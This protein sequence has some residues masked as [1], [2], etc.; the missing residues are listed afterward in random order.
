MEGGRRFRRCLVGGTFDRLHAGHRLL[1]DAAQTA[2][3]FVEI[4]ITSDA[5]A[6]QKSDHIQSFETRRECLLDWIEQHA[7]RR[8][9]VHQLT[10][11]HGPAPTHSKADCIVATPETRGQ[12][13]RINEKRLAGNLPPLAV[14]EVG[15]MMDINGEVISSSRIRNGHI[16]PEGH[17]WF[18][19]D[20]E[21]RTLRMHPRAEPELKSPM[22]VL[23]AGPEDDPEI[24]MLAALDDLDLDRLMLVAVGDVTVRT[25]LSIGITPDL[26]LV[27]GQTKR[28]ALVKEEQVNIGAFGTVLHAENPA[29][30]LTPSLLGAVRE[31]LSD[32]VPVVVVVDGEEDLAPLFIHVLAP[33]NAVV[34]YGQP[35]EG[36]VVQ[37]SHLGTKQRCR[38]LLELF[39]VI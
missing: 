25:L 23:Y 31:A 3:D 17:P 2:A 35:K 27:D 39:E 24:A 6:E 16:D 19:P 8:A 36:V 30:V 20:W 7:P 29:G 33:I 37:P 11:V 34:L 14:L 22:G 18:S 9:S 12:C 28:Q 1:L 32:E 5:M 4:H 38:R 21:G 15:H 10:D 13:E 26:A